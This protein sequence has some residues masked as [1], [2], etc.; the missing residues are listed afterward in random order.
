MTLRDILVCLDATRTGDGRLDPERV[1]RRRFGSR[2]CGRA[3]G[4]SAGGG[5][6][7]SRPRGKSCSE[8]SEPTPS[9]SASRRELALAG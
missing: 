6:A 5:S 1:F 4:P 8:L 9:S 3:P 7:N 2:F